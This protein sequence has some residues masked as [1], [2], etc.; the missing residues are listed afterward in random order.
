MKYVFKMMV[1]VMALGMLVLQSCQTT[2]N[3][4]YVLKDV[5]ITDKYK[6]AINDTYENDKVVCYNATDG[7]RSHW[8]EDPLKT[9]YVSMAK[10]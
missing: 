3:K 6:A 1:F 10:I 5:T 8:S 4:L 9:R 2:S 7:L